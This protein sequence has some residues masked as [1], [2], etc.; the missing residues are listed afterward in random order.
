MGTIIHILQLKKIEF[1][2]DSNEVLI[3]CELD[4]LGFGSRSSFLISHTELNKI[5]SELQL[6]NEDLNLYDLME[7]VDIDSE[8]TLY[9]L[10]LEKNN[11]QNT[12]LPNFNSNMV[13]KQIRA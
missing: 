1:Q 7:K 12:W 4:Q 6:K 13:L 5:I 8:T 11:I 3:S 2:S 10:N 9:T